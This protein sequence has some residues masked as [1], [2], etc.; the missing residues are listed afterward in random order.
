MYHFKDRQLFSIYQ[1]TNSAKVIGI[2]R[3]YLNDIVNGRSDCS[4][5][6]AYCITKFIN[7]D[8]EIEDFFE[9]V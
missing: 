9:R 8:K 7:K 5:K 3:Q 1:I 6:V 2:S 4:K